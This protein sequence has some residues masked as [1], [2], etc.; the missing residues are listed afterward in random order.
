MTVQP[1]STIVGSIFCRLIGVSVVA[2]N[3][4]LSRNFP[5]PEN[6]I[7][8]DFGASGVRATLVSF[9]T[10]PTVPESKS[11]SAKTNDVTHAT[12]LGYGYDRVASGSEMDLRLRELLQAKFETEYMQ[13]ASIAG[14]QRAIAKLWKEASRAKM[15]LS[16]N[17]ESRVSVRDS[18][19][20]RDYCKISHGYLYP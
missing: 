5:A 10:I 4:A 16:A 13:G 9:H 2:I 15:V 8:Y 11:K 12:V 19:W 3:F 17:T 6:H 18:F 7:M 14:E 1:V 20:L